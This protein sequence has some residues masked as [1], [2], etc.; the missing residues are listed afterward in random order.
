M[1][2]IKMESQLKKFNKYDQRLYN[3]FNLVYESFISEL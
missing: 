1:W 2:S 3:I